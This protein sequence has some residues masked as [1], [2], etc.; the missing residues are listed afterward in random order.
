MRK[1][2][3]SDQPLHSH[4]T[5][6]PSISRRKFLKNGAIG[7]AGLLAGC[8]FAKKGKENIPLTP[9]EGGIKGG[10]FIAW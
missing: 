9:F 5:D 6:N 10:C 3:Q 1:S 4:K 8:A 2:V 7:M